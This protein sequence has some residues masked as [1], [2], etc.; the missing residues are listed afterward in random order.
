MTILGYRPKKEGESDHEEEF[1]YT[2]RE[3][4]APAPP[5]TL[6]HQDMCRPPYEDPD[7]QRQLVGSFRLLST[8][9]TKIMAHGSQVSAKTAPYSQRRWGLPKAFLARIISSA[10]KGPNN[11]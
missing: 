5:P 6:S 11:E 9:H 1:Y 2:E 3:V 10:V 8:P 4:C 7:Y